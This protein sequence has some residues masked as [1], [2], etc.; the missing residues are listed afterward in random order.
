MLIEKKEKE[1]T[2]VFTAN[3]DVIIQDMPVYT[4]KYTFSDIGKVQDLISFAQK[5]K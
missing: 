3:T 2:F 1:K 5:K 4:N